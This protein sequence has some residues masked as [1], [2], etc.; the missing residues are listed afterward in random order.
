MLF[1]VFFSASLPLPVLSHVPFCALSSRRVAFQ[2]R[3]ARMRVP[4]SSV[5]PPQAAVA[6][7]LAE[8]RCDWQHSDSLAH[9]PVKRLT[10]YAAKR[11]PHCVPNDETRT[12]F[13]KNFRTQ[14]TRD[15]CNLS[16][17]LLHLNLFGVVS[18]HSLMFAS[19]PAGKSSCHSTSSSPHCCLTHAYLESTSWVMSV[20]MCP[21]VTTCSLCK[22]LYS[23]VIMQYPAKASLLCVVKTLM[24]CGLFNMFIRLF[25]RIGSSLSHLVSCLFMSLRRF[26]LL[27]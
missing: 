2:E 8:L 27:V 21:V 24:V 22:L 19:S 16:F 7:P 10:V 1:V 14:K 17:T 5:V 11:R 23:P 12:G 6:P 3:R 15:A 9:L 4:I 13:L 20:Q 25:P 18:L 26:S